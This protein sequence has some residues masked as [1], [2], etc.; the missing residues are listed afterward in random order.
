MEVSDRFMYVNIREYLAQGDNEKVG[1]PELIRMISDFSCPKNPDVE[2]FLKICGKTCSFI[3]NDPKV[4]ISEY[5][6][7][8]TKRCRAA[9]HDGCLRYAPGER[10]VYVLKTLIK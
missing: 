10:P 7:R 1:E 2:Q 3:S 5:H 8:W 6:V 4:V 9:G